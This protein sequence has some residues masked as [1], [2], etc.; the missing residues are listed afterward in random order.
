MLPT[1][2]T[3][4]DLR[5]ALFEVEVDP[6]LQAQ[7]LAWRLDGAPRGPDGLVLRGATWSAGS[8]CLDPEKLLT[9][10]LPRATSPEGHVSLVL[11]SGPGAA[12][13]RWQLAVDGEAIDLRPPAG[14]ITRD[15]LGPFARPV[16]PRRLT[17]R[18]AREARPDSPC[19]HGSLAALR[20]LPPAPAG[21][22]RGL[23]D[24]WARTFAPA[25]D[26]GHPVVP[27]RWVAGGSLSRARPGLTPA[28]TGGGLT[29][30]LRA[31]Q[32]LDF[33]WSH[34]PGDSRAAHDL[35]LNLRDLRLG[36][37]ARV[38]IWDGDELL[39]EVDPPERHDGAWQSPPLPWR[40][41]GPL[42]RLGL[43]LLAED[44]RAQVQVR[45]LALFSR[46]IAVTG[47][48]A[49]RDGDGPQPLH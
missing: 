47:V 4:A 19:P 11:V 40:P 35:V 37:D 14:T 31:G 17:L 26:L 6:A 48:V 8:L 44:E 15:T 38:E 30:T 28:P 13:E 42:V 29:L 20:L 21:L 16:T 33:A 10:D 49:P 3:R 46:E 39:A 32:R 36:R 2:V 1:R 34:V 43:V 22:A 23:G 7:I 9:I 45:D 12:P 18:G 24:A 41:R 25:A 27:A 5:M